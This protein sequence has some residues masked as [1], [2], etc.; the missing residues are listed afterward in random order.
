MEFSFTR[1]FSRRNRNGAEYIAIGFRA[2]FINLFQA[3]SMHPSGAK[4]PFLPALD[5]MAKAMPLQSTIYESTI[6][7]TRSNN[8]QASDTR[9]GCCRSDGKT[10]R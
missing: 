1:V 6:Y 2:C 3:K 5:G 7:E 4:A 9:N 8:F 10:R